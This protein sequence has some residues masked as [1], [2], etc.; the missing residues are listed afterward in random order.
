M[1]VEYLGEKLRAIRKSK[2]WTQTQLAKRLHLVTG[3]ISAYETGQKY[4]SIEVLIKICQLFDTSSDYLLGLNDD[5]MP[6]KMSALSEAQMQPF[7][8]IIAE[9]AQYNTLREKTSRDNEK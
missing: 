8:Q 3:T 7:L 4:P 6:L 1:G 9:V 2:G 5:Q